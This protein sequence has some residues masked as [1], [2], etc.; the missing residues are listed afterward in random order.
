MRTKVLII[1]VVKKDNQILMCKKPEESAPYKETWYLF[2]AELTPDKAP[3]KALRDLVKTQSGIDTELGEQFSWDTEVKKDLDGI[4]KHF[5][6]LD[7]IC[8]YVSGE[9]TAAPGI[10]KIEWVLIQNLG[11]YDL[12][13]PSVEVFKKL[14]YL[15]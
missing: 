10:E 1:A 4:E 11:D 8:N 14:G 3:E 2:G 9:P 6:Y 13:P 5:V 15:K 12:V 7:V